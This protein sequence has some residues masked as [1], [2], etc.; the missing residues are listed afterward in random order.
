MIPDFSKG[1][2]GHMTIF[3]LV[4]NLEKLGHNL[5]IW[6]KD[7]NFSNHPEG[8]SVDIK[9]YFQNINANVFELNTHFAFIS[10][11]AIVATS[12]DTVELVKSHNSFIEKFYLVQ[13]YEPLFLSQ[14]FKFS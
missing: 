7:Y 6:I 14:R 12:W 9:K 1:G 11:D 5:T 10:G 3:R 8:P 4:K 13:D 2:G